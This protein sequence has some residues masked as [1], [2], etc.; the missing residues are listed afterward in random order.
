MVCVSFTTQRS[1]SD[2]TTVCAPGDHLFFKASTVVAY[3]FATQYTVKKIRSYLEGGTFTKKSSCSAEL[4]KRTYDGL[5]KSDFTP[6]YILT[7][8]SADT[9]DEDTDIGA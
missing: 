9:L 6:N 1:G 2:T 3:N 7:A 5:L 4:L 8:L